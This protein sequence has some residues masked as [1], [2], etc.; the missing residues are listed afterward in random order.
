MCSNKH[1]VPFRVLL[2]CPVPLGHDY[3]WFSFN[4][5]H[6]SSFTLLVAGTS[7][8]EHGFVLSCGV[9]TLLDLFL[10]GKN[11]S[12]VWREGNY[13]LHGNQ[14]ISLMNVSLMLKELRFIFWNSLEVCTFYCFE[15]LDKEEP[16]SNLI[17]PCWR[18]FYFSI[19]I[20][21]FGC[22]VLD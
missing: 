17:R 2:F 5:K 1:I 16:K 18:R 20:V 19:D 4:E 11:S 13:W 6:P 15:V 21:L 22:L 7:G 14:T 8:L 9:F 12:S 3:A 10:Q